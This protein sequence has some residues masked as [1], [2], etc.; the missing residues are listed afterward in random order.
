MRYV[1]S[2]NLAAALVASALAFGVAPGPAKAQLC[3]KPKKGCV[4]TNDI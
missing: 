3:S 2:T 4:V 1:N